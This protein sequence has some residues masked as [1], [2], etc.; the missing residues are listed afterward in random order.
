MII[1]KE[2]L[3]RSGI[4]IGKTDTIIT[5]NE[6]HNEIIEKVKQYSES[7]K[8][9]KC[10]YEFEGDYGVYK[11][12][13]ELNEIEDRDKYVIENNVKV[14]QKWYESDLTLDLDEV[15]GLHGCVEYF[16][17]LVDSFIIDVYPDLKNNIM[18]N[19]TIT[20]YEDGH[21][22]IPHQDGQNV[23]RKCGILIYLSDEKDYNDGGGKLITKVDNNTI[24]VYPFKE[25]FVI[26]DFTKNNLL[27][28]VEHV[29]NGF[30]RY[31]YIDFVYNK[32]EFEREQNKSKII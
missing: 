24:D 7:K 3:L 10:R 1:D 16:K 22:I 20:L 31:A 14:F 11:R 32:S 9:F 5:D 28:S 25:N 13:V 8:A 30:K 27:H 2:E 26:L 6:L 18:H 15:R 4:H 23:G 12:R 19:S 21:F 17:N 29:K